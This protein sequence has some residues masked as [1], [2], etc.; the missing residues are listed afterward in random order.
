MEFKIYKEIYKSKEREI[1]IQRRGT[2]IF[3]VVSN[4]SDL[5]GR[6]LDE[7]GLIKKNGG[8]TARVI[9]FME[10]MREAGTDWTLAYYD[11]LIAFKNPADRVTYIYNRKY[12]KKRFTASG[13]N[14]IFD[15]KSIRFD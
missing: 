8:F 11:S 9:K 12:F 6:I 3:Q 2:W 15:C 4:T 1:A 14:S 7:E 10:L 13:D 5:D